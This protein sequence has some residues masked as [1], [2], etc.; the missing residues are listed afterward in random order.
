M[1]KIWIYWPV[2]TF[3]YY[4]KFLFHLSQH[5]YHL[6]NENYYPDFLRNIRNTYKALRSIIHKAKLKSLLIFETFCKSMPYVIWGKCFFSTVLEL[7]KY[8]LGI[9]KKISKFN[10]SFN[11]I[12]VIS[13]QHRETQN[14]ILGK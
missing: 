3:F 9:N 7:C 11:D 10:A 2:L 14:T 5:L 4:S 1:G 13:L 12:S 6:R 8:H